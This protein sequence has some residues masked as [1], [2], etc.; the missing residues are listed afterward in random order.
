LP[1]DYNEPG[2]QFSFGGAF[3]KLVDLFLSLLANLLVS[4]FLTHRARDILDLDR[5]FVDRRPAQISP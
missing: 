4:T 3:E 2:P 1:L 5:I